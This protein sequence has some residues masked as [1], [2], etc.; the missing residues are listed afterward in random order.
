[1]N[2]KLLKI[3]IIII[4]GILIGILSKWGDI[5]PGDNIIK[6]F[7]WISSGIILWLVIGTLFIILSNNKKSF[8]IYY[9]LFMISM[10]I[11]YY[12]FSYIIV[13]YIYFRIIKFWIIMFI[14][15][16][17]LGNILYNKRYTKLFL[18]LFII[19]SIIFIIF[20]AI[21]INGVILQAIIPEI[22]LVILTIFIINKKINNK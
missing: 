15:S 3:T 12:L 11:S 1:M 5:I 18:I 6:Y 21:K 2:N 9:L 13:N 4:T 17:I 14:C 22:I 8:N 19:T 7:G 16:L 10:L 20:D